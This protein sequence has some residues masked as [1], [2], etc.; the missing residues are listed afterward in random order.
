VHAVAQAI[1]HT[2]GLVTTLAQWLEAT[3]PDEVG[4]A[5][6]AGIAAIRAA[7]SEWNLTLGG[8]R[9]TT[10]PAPSAPINDRPAVLAARSAR[11]SGRQE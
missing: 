8:P 4:P 9:S 2:R 11:P 7:L 5:L 3:P 10:A 1:R 6:V